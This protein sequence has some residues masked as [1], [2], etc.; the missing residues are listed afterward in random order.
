[1]IR[2]IVEPNEL[3]CRSH[4]EMSLEPRALR[5][6]HFT[7]DSSFCKFC[8]SV[9]TVIRWHNSC[10]DIGP[11]GSELDTQIARHRANLD[12]CSLKYIHSCFVAIS[13]HTIK[14]GSHVAK[15][16]QASPGSSRNE[17]HRRLTSSL[18]WTT[19]A[20][21]IGIMSDRRCQQT[22]CRERPC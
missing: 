7:P 6:A 9:A 21:K 10:F 19:D 17:Q 22:C 16:F 8:W 18:R 3:S 13:V 2:G 4:P 20:L 14:Q 12:Q 5:N 11:A 15:V 1:M